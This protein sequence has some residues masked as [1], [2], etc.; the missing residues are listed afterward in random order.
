M[1]AIADVSPSLGSSPEH[2]ISGPAQD[3]AQGRT[4]VGADSWEARANEPGEDSCGT[5][6]CVCCSNNP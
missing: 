4:G 1:N 5:P 2:E 6:S 3:S